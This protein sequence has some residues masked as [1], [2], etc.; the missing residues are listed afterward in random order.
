MNTSS[1]KSGSYLC[2][3]IQFSAIFTLP[4][5]IFRKS[6]TCE[7]QS[8]LR[9]ILGMSQF[10]QLL[11]IFFFDEVVNWLGG[12]SSLLFFGLIGLLSEPLF[13]MV[14]LALV[15][16]DPVEEL[17][18]LFGLGNFDGSFAEDWTEAHLDEAL[19]LLIVL[20]RSKINQ[21]GNY[22]KIR[23]MMF[24]RKFRRAFVNQNWSLVL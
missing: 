20:H 4:L 13:P 16:G 6:L 11:Y 24:S 19:V 12:F 9:N 18:L 2:Y 21:I 1:S 17:I 7:Q 10:H 15:I 3:S 14:L 22:S 23:Y 5:S 8:F